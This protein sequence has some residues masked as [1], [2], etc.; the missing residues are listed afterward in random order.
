MKEEPSIGEYWWVRKT[1]GSITIGQFNID[2]EGCGY[3]L[4]VG[5]GDIAYSQDELELVSRIE[6]PTISNGFRSN[7]YSL[8]AGSST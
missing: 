3:F 2:A 6:P 8:Y 1:S 7:G 4:L 5:A